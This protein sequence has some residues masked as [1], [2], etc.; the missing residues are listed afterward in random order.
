MAKIFMLAT[1]AAGLQLAGTLIEPDCPVM[2]SGFV[3]L[4]NRARDFAFFTGCPE[5]KMALG[6]FISLC[7]LQQRM[8]L[9]K[10]R[11]LIRCLPTMYTVSLAFG[12]W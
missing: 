5:G 8:Y 2:E 1:M 4:S 7:R 11:K 10:H 12:L 9:C 6:G 3:Y